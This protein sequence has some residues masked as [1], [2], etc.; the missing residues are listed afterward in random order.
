MTKAEYIA[1]H[2]ECTERMHKIT[3][4]KNADYTGSGDDPFA[5]FR[6]VELIGVCS[7]EQGI[8]TRISDKLARLSSFCQRGEL[9]VKDESVEDSLLD[10]ANYTI[11]MAGYLRSK[12]NT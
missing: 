4:A 9:S 12:K 6:I 8:L 7:A 1:F 2:K 11:L 5:N 3:L 10:L